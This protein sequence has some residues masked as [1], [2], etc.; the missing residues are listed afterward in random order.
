MASPASLTHYSSA[1][2]VALI[3]FIPTDE[4]FA[5]SPSFLYRYG[6]LLSF[7]QVGCWKDIIG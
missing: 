1:L 2:K 4:R 7:N 6:P 5:R 3:A